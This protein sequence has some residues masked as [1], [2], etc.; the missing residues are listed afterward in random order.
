[1]VVSITLDCAQG[2]HDEASA[3]PAHPCWGWMKSHT[4]SLGGMYSV[5]RITGKVQSSRSGSDTI[6]VYLAEEKHN[7][8]FLVGKVNTNGKNITSFDF[9]VSSKRAAY[10]RFQSYYGSVDYSYATVTATPATIPTKITLDSPSGDPIVQG[11]DVVISGTVETTSGQPIANGVVGIVA[12]GTNYDNPWPIGTTTTD[13]QGWFSYTIPG[14]H[15]SVISTDENNLAQAGAQFAGRLNGGIYGD[16]EAYVYFLVLSGVPCPN[17]IDEEYCASE[18]GCELG[19][20]LCEN[21]ILYECQQKKDCMTCYVQKGVCKHLTYMTCKY[22]SHTE[23]RRDQGMFDFTFEWHTDTGVHPCRTITF[24]YRK[25]GASASPW[26]PLEHTNLMPVCSMWGIFG[27]EYEL[28]FDAI[29]FT[30]GEFEF[31]ARFEGSDDMQPCEKVVYLKILPEEEPPVCIEGNLYSPQTCWDG[32]TIYTQQ[33][34]NQTLVPSG[35]VCPT[36]VCNEGEFDQPRLC[37]DGVTTIYEKVCVGNAWVASG[38]VCPPV[39]TEGEQSEPFTCWDGS[40][41]YKRLCQNDAWVNSGQVCPSPPCAEGDIKC[42]DGIEYECVG[43]EW[44]PTGEKCIE[45]LNKNLILAV[46]VI[47]VGVVTALMLMR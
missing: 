47:G 27:E 10:V 18:S 9:P 29:D 41:I 40:L 28:S 24:A 43:Y 25:R 26:I 1:M 39:C 15:F 31:R 38:Q 19:T 44:V 36:H 30:A 20:S 4:Y 34:I 37:R 32:S 42:E 6:G 8:Y 35:Q 2:L 45:S 5:T 16:S 7:W 23:I 22:Q 3:Y 11:T 13:S 17:G 21:G 33:C 12:A 14:T 46:G